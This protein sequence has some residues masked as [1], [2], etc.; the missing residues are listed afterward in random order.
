ME[1]LLHALTTQLVNILNKKINKQKKK[2]FAN[3][4]NVKVI[5]LLE[6]LKRVKNF[7]DAIISLNVNMHLGI[8][9]QVINVLN[10]MIY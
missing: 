2:L 7:M 3:V 6:K 5:L 4:Q 1:S 8:N 9:Q 10:V